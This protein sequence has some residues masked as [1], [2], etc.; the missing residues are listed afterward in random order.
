MLDI[1][2]LEKINTRR[3][4]NS[5]HKIATVNREEFYISTERILTFKHDG[6]EYSP[7]FS[8]N[9]MCEFK[10]KVQSMH[11]VLYKSMFLMWIFLAIS[12]LFLI[13][14]DSITDWHIFVSISVSCGP[15][16]LLSSI[17]MWRKI[18]EINRLVKEKAQLLSLPLPKNY[19]KVRAIQASKAIAPILA[20]EL[21]GE[22]SDLPESGVQEIEALKTAIAVGLEAEEQL[23]PVLSDTSTEI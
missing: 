14:L 4:N 22:A 10:S 7:I 13:S 20:L 1:G 15:V 6:R 9:E 5:F 21:L 2:I 16:F 18:S 17:L 23:S 8:F 19:W 11:G 3:L 12:V